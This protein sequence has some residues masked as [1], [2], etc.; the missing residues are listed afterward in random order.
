M[1]W[2]AVHVCTPSSLE[3]V[4]F[5][6]YL[7]SQEL[8]RCLILPGA[9]SHSSPL[10]SIA[11]YFILCVSMWRKVLY[12]ILYVRDN[13]LLPLVLVDFTIH[14]ACCSSLNVGCFTVA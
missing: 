9:V 11:M 14:V 3:D 10:W 13:C 8:I 5:S 7:C 6:G 4:G 2:F 1:L 12:A